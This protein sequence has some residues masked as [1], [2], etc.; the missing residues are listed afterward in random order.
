MGRCFAI[1]DV[2]AFPA[3]ELVGDL[4]ED[5]ESTLQLGHSGAD[6]AT[7]KRFLHAQGFLTTRPA[8]EDLA[9]ATFDPETKAGVIAFQREAS[10]PL[11]HPHPA[12]LLS[13]SRG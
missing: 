5:G 7:L 8:L 13:Q 9:T 6:I 10:A 1:E 2:D 3:H 12:R 4:W 11:A